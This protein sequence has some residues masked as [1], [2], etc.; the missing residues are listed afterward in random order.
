LKNQRLKFKTSPFRQIQH[1]KEHQN[2]TTNKNS[3]KSAPE[4][5][6]KQKLVLHI[7]SE[8]KREIKKEKINHS[9]HIETKVK[10]AF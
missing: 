6:L 7:K 8:R 10:Q 2:F 5:G 3:I 9:H 4:K 1:T